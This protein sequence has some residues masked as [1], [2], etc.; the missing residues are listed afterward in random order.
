MEILFVGDVNRHT[1]GFQRLA[2]FRQLGHNV[3][4]VPEFCIRGKGIDESKSSY[5]VKLMW[6]LGF[7]LD[8]ACANTK[9]RD[10]LHK[11]QD[12]NLVWIEK[13]NTIYPS[14]LRLIK[15]IIPHVPLASFSE[16]DMY[17]WHNRSFYYTWGLKHYDIIFT[18]KTYNLTELKKLGGRRTEL[19]LDS[20]DEALHRPVSLSEKE[21]KEYETDVGFIGT[22]ENDRAEQM[23]FL[24]ENGIKVEIYGNEWDAWLFKH[25]NLI[26]HNTPIYNEEYVKKIN[27]TKI[28]LCFLRKMNRDAVTSRSVEIPACGSFMLAERTERHKDFFKEGEEAEFFGSREELLEKIRY[29]LTHTDERQKIA[30]RGRKRCFDG[31]YSNRDQLARALFFINSINI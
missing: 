26:V 24:A 8:E 29:Y 21:K 30:E 17:A 19:V 12:I 20:F 27:A 4:V 10:I 5:F 7:P 16:D 28:N 11:G 25:P 22:F 23:L 1:R 31:G 13:G 6:K 18:T 3:I 9:I 14:T 2:V 15:R